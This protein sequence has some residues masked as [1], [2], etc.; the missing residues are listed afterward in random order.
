MRRLDLA[1][2]DG[3]QAAPHDLGDVGAL[4][5]RDHEQGSH[6]EARRVDEGGNGVERE[7]LPDEEERDERHATEQL[8]V[9]HG[10]DPDRRQARPAPEGGDQP[11]GHGQHDPRHGDEERELQPAP[12]V[13]PDAAG[14]HHDL[15][16]GR[17]ATP[18]ITQSHRASQRARRP[19]ARA[20]T[21]TTASPT[22]RIP[23]SG[24]ADERQHGHDE[25]D[26]RPPAADR[27][28]ARPGTGARGPWVRRA[29][30]DRRRPRRWPRRRTARARRPGRRPP[31]RVAT[32]GRRELAHHEQPQVATHDL[33]V[34]GHEEESD[35]PVG[36][37]GE[38]RTEDDRQG[39][40]ERCAGQVLAHPGRLRRHPR[41]RLQ[42]GGHRSTSCKRRLTT[43]AMIEIA[44]EMTR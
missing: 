43:L 1:L 13:P 14:G 10:Q 31:P 38:G 24:G 16:R 39:G 23:G 29:A 28:E 17:M 11:D 18:E 32:A 40:V 8:D 33:P 27:G 6:Q 36:R 34:G 15:Q 4:E 3:L 7:V 5:Q 44:M 12:P 41:R 9:A 25:G 19:R 26:E 42:G 21:T 30:S 2:G 35:E 20:P 37:P 22:S